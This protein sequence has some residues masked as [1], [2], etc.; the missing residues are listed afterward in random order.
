MMMSVVAFVVERR[1]LRAIKR[2]GRRSPLDDLRR[3]STAGPEGE[4]LPSPAKQQV[5][6]QS[7]RE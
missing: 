4:A 7:E 5:E 1:L 3:S 2:G 6:D